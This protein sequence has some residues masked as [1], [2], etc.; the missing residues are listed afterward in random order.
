MNTSQPSA[1]EARTG[2]AIR[3]FEDHYRLQRAMVA[4]VDRVVSLMPGL[5]AG[6]R[7]TIQPPRR[8]LLSNAGHL[9]DVIITTAL[10]PVLHHSFPGIEIGT[11]TG[12]Q[13]SCVVSNHP[14]IARTHY[15]DHWYL[16]RDT[17]SRL[18]K[19]V[20]YSMVDRRRVARELAEHKYDAAIDVRAW[21]PNFISVLW[22]A[23][24]PA[25]IGF[26]RVGLGPLLT[27]PFKHRYHR[28]HELEYQFE[29]LGALGVPPDSFSLAHPVLAPVTPGAAAE[30]RQVLGAAVKYRVLHMASSTSSR[31]WPAQRWRELAQSL[32]AQGIT[33]V[34]TGRGDRDAALAS[35][36][37]RSVPGCVDATGRLG[38]SG[39]VALIA[40]AELIYSV[41]TSVGHVGAA[42]NKPVV[43]I[44]GGMADPM[45]WR[46]Y[47]NTVE[48]ATNLLDCHPC[49]VKR[50]CRSRPCL[51]LLETRTVVA[52]AN[53]LLKQVA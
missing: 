16:R 24:I 19:F 47:G 52:S 20:R 7:G 9:G 40:G 46:P 36:V 23:G 39:L 26:D 5:S 32:V 38:W 37:V 29:L 35:E 25:R 28:R 4:L 13:A 1:E 12:S 44:Y 48:V 8:V 17:G 18:A 43:A 22:R 11:L 42:L 31:D 21:F 50:G 41:E 27:H 45:H 34:L 14:L 30:A 51:T 2:A 53:Q 49:F 10:L 33:P 6:S 3:R 15:L